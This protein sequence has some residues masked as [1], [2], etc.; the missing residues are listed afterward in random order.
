MHAQVNGTRLWFDVDGPSLVACA[1]LGLP[2][3]APA[4]EPKAAPDVL[5]SMLLHCTACHGARRKEAGLAL[6]SRAAMLK[7]GKSGP[8]LVP[9]KPEQSLILKR[10]QADQM[11][12][13]EQIMKANV[14]PFT[15]NEFERSTQWIALG[16]P[17]AAVLVESPNNSGLEDAM[18]FLQRIQA[19]PTKFDAAGLADYYSADYFSAKER[20]L[21]ACDRLAF[22]HHSLFVGHQSVTKRDIHRATHRPRNKW[23]IANSSIWT[24]RFG[25]TELP[26]C[27]CVA[28]PSIR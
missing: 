20:F 25:A 11:P 19:R 21:A 5:P 24:Y 26:N 15:A 27:T 12:P 23:H 17:D 3:A 18:S 13:F 9:G 16:A 4:D 28:S 6:R 22:E 10:V 7:G 14:K 1:D 2:C 8:A